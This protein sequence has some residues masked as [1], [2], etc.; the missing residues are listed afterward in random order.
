MSSAISLGL[1]LKGGSCWPFADLYF[2]LSCLH[3]ALPWALL[4]PPGCVSCSRRLW[5]VDK[6]C[7]G[8]ADRAWGADGGS[9]ASPAQS[10]VPQRSPSRSGCCP[11][12]T[13]LHGT[14]HPGR[15]KGLLTDTSPSS[16]L[17]LLVRDPLSHRLPPGG[18]DGFPVTVPDGLAVT[19]LLT[20]FCFFSVILS[21]HISFFHTRDGSLSACS[22]WTPSTGG[23]SGLTVV[24]GR[25]TCGVAAAEAAPT[26]CPPTHEYVP[27]S[28]AP[29]Q[30][31]HSGGWPG[32]PRAL[33]V[34]PALTLIMMRPWHL[35]ASQGD[36]HWL[37]PRP[38]HVPLTP[39]TLAVLPVPGC[40][41]YSVPPP[42]VQQVL[43]PNGIS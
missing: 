16:P 14:P 13:F 39:C 40:T 23:H 38:A 7:G 27:A 29:G 22:A 42:S 2:P 26:L 20:C 30:Q 4:G 37:C 24:R 31:G 17:H 18:G 10:R 5:C 43:P 6:L 33:S 9:L 11:S 8:Q 1:L 3:W 28:A 41:L 25:K 21:L 34:A 19:L 35:Q 36:S 32:L 15:C 12:F